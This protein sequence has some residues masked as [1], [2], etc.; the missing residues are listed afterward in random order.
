MAGFTGPDFF[1]EMGIAISDIS[2]QGLEGP[3]PEI[4]HQGGHPHQGADHRHHHHRLQPFPPPGLL[5]GGAR[6]CLVLL[7]K[8]WRWRWRWRAGG[9]GRKQPESIL[10]SAPFPLPPPG[11]SLPLLQKRESVLQK[12]PEG[13]STSDPGSPNPWPSALRSA[14]IFLSVGVMVLISSVGWVLIMAT[15]ATGFNHS[16]RQD[17]CAGRSQGVSGPAA[18]VLALACGGSWGKQTGRIFGQPPLSC[19]R[20]SCCRGSPRFFRGGNLANGL[21]RG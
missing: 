19:P 18:Q 5:E 20:H 16:H 7:L 12:P 14:L 9:H 15:T 8:C 6:G 10:R 2:P 4:G 21:P 17:P 3:H 13:C 1:S 11:F